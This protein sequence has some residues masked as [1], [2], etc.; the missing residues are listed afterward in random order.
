MHSKP[1][2]ESEGTFETDWLKAARSCP[3]CETSDQV[4]YRVWE[5]NCGGY[6][7]VQ[8]QCRACGKVWWV[9]GSDA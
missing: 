7:D 8:C 6:E 3:E 1:M 9:E 5:S 4:Y 2:H